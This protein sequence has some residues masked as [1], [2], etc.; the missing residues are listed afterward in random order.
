MRRYL[1][2]ITLLWAV[3]ATALLAATVVRPGV[4]PGAATSPAL[5]GRPPAAEAQPAASPGEDLR[6]PAR[7]EWLGWQF[8]RVTTPRGK[9]LLFNPALNDPRATFR[10]QESP[11]SLEDLDKAD[12]ILAA[13]G[14]AETRA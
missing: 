11:L 4:L 8:F 2:T 3:T 5:P 12:L 7:L 14:H 13:D 10:N 9:V 6:P 1:G